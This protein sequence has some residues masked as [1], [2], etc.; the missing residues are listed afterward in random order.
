MKAM[1]LAAGL[2]TRLRPYSSLRPKPLF[3]VVD[4]PLLLHTIKQ[5]RAYGIEEILI[6]CHHLKDQIVTLLSG[7]PDIYLQQEEKILGTGGGMR[8]AVQFFGKEPV[9]IVN[10]DI[11]HTIDIRSVIDNHHSSGAAATLVVHDYPRFNSVTIDENRMIRCFG[12]LGSNKKQLAFTG[13][14]IIDPGLLKIIQEDTFANII[15]CYT[16][17]IGKGAA[18]IGLEVENHYWT[19][20]GTPQNYL[21]LHGALL[22][23]KRFGCKDPFFIGQNVTMADDVILNDWVSI[24]SSSSIGSGASLKRVVVWDGAMVADGAQISDAIIV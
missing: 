17:W 6:N 16:W 19:D 10:G 11:F 3:P 2:G 5:L 21:D 15:D 20:M 8:K 13:I 7:E 18:I 23:E 22:K 14:H 12:E 9:L 24:G 1:I 4:N